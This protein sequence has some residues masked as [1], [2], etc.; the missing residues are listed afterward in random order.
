MQEFYQRLSDRIAVSPF[1]LSDRMVVLQLNA[2]IHTWAIFGN[3]K[4]LS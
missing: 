4:F 2:A 1:E 3:L